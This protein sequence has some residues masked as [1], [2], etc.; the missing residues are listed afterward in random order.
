MFQSVNEKEKGVREGY[1][2]Y[3][4]ECV[5][6]VVHTILHTKYWL[7]KKQQLSLMVTHTAGMLGN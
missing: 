3:F 7:K 6:E 5:S 4:K 1:T 2:F